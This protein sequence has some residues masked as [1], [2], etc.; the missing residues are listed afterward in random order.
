MTAQSIQWQSWE[1]A[2]EADRRFRR[3]CL[4]IAL[5]LILLGVVVPFLELVGLTR[6][7]GTLAGARTVELLPDTPAPAEEKVEEPKPVEAPEPEPVEPEPVPEPVAKPEP[8]KPQPKPVDQQKVVESARQVAARSGVMAFANQLQDL[9]TNT[10]PGLNSNT[11]SL[12]SVNVAESG[13]VPDDRSVIADAAQASSGGIGGTG[14][15]SVK[16]A[17]TGTGLDQRKTTVIDSPVGFG[18]DKTR[19]GQGGDKLIAGRTLSEIQLVF[20]RNKGAISSIFNRA[21]RD[22]PDLR[23]RIIINFVV[24][25]DGSV[26]NLEMV[27]SDLGN[28]DLEKK[29][30][31]RVQLINFGAKSVPPFPLK[32]FPIVLL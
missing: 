12:S 22:F 24:A 10:L 29:I 19:P 16:R 3:L 15:G 17:Q 26:T 9:R 21:L 20:D 13:G 30:L 31:Q 11:Q 14:S 1:L 25:P 28:P 32:D 2:E 6:G 7:G 5:P 8:P 23:G 27:R 4:I 18:Q